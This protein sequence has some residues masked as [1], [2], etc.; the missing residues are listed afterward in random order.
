MAYPII[1]GER[2]QRFADPKAPAVKEL[3]AEFLAT[4]WSPK[5]TF[6]NRM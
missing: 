6:A 1:W 3:D 4:I 5:L 2:F